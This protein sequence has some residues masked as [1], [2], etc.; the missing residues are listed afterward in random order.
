ML[1]PGTIRL[2]ID[3]SG[4]EM[5]TMFRPMKLGWNDVDEFYV[6]QIQAGLSRTK[7]IGIKFSKSYG[8]LHAGRKFSSNLTGMEGALP[9]HFNKSAEEICEVLNRCKQRWGESA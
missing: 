5:K 6:G 7:M 2:R 1:I 4:I 9:N 3:H 8:K